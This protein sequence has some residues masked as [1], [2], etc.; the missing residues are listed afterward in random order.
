MAI[1]AMNVTKLPVAD[2]IVRGQD[3]ITRSTNNP[4]APGNAAALAAFAAAQEELVQLNNAYV[5]ARTV[6]DEASSAREDG[7]A[8]WLAALTGLAGVT[9]NATG[10]DK[11]KILSTGFDVRAERTPAQPLEAPVN[12]AVRTNGSPGV[13]KLSW[14]L[15]GADTFLVQMSDDPMNPNSWKQ[16]MVTTK[17]RIEVPGAEPGK[18][19][20]FRVAGVNA[21]GQGPWCLPAQRPVM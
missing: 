1:I 10:G 15:D 12:L 2:K 4:N 21:L 3:I 13:S 11:T 17:T 7:V 14:E 20:W 6:C 8:R 19:C 16:V 18:P 5:A 9:E